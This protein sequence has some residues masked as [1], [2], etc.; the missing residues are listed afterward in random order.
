M[1]PN[2]L[3]I[4]AINWSTLKH[5]RVSPRHYLHALTAPHADTTSRAMGR[6]LHTLVLEPQKF[7]AAYVVFDGDRRGNAW[8]DFQALHEGKTILRAV[9]YDT[10]RRQADA[11]RPLL[12][13]GEVEQVLRWTD[14]A[15]GLQC[16][17]IA[18]HVGAG[19]LIDL[20]GT[21]RLD[22][23][24]RLAVRDGFAHQLA[25]YRRA[26][27]DGKPGGDMPCR[28]LSVET[29]APHDVALLTLSPTLLDWADRELSALLARVAACQDSGIWPGRYPDGGT[30][31]L[32]VW[33]SGDIDTSGL[34]DDDEVSS[35]DL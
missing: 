5:M 22:M 4:R 24:E 34:E 8:K 3:A 21:G 7:D 6:A 18:D 27:N 26:L 10:V 20:K 14:P 31:E 1:D 9:E 17:G 19:G 35:V 12:P 23:F 33:M 11:A 16:K 2:Y 30:L 28:L 32:P 13:P 25:F 15:T 29:L